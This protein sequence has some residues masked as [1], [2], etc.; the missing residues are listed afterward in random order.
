MRIQLHLGQD[1][2]DRNCILYTGNDH[3]KEG[4]HSWT[5]NS[6]IESRL[7]PSFMSP[8]KHLIRF[9]A[10]HSKPKSRK[11]HFKTRLPLFTHCST[12]LFTVCNHSVTFP[13][14]VPC[15]RSSVTEALKSCF[16]DGFLCHQIA[17]IAIGWIVRASC[18]WS[19]SNFN[20]CRWRLLAT[21]R[22]DNSIVL[23]SIDSVDGELKVF[24][25]VGRFVII[26]LWD[27]GFIVFRT[28]SRHVSVTCDFN[29]VDYSR[30]NIWNEC[31]EERQ[32]SKVCSNKEI[33]Q[34]RKVLYDINFCWS[35]Y[36]VR[37]INSL[38]TSKNLY[39]LYVRSSVFHES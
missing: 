33:I 25:V 5:T 14:P 36:I 20:R 18:S 3:H 38:T 31:L 10:T 30:C 39:S 32:W 24:R 35:I 4:I 16:V 28:V 27:N 19:G 7:I 21:S 15:C 6:A 1:Y 12:V 22:L 13:I 11:S 37:R 8:R 29:I 2:A 34:I 26:R 23:W 9:F 17:N